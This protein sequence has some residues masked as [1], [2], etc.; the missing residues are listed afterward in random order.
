MKRPRKNL[1]ETLQIGGMIG[2]TTA[3]MTEPRLIS[4]N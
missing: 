2:D 3:I 1:F 4:M